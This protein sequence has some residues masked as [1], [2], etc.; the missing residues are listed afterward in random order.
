MNVLVVDDSRAIRNL[1]TA[2]VEEMGFRVLLAADGA[3]ALEVFGQHAVDLVLMDVEMPGINGFETTR[4][5]RARLK[6]EWLPI[7]YL[8]S[9][10]TDDYFVEG[11]QAGGDAYL[12][13]PVNGPVLQSM[14]RAMGRISAMRAALLKAN[15]DLERMAFVDILTDLTNRRGF[16]NLYAKEWARSNRDCSPLSV[17]LVDIDYFKGYNDNYGH[18]EG[19]DCLR[20]VARQ[21]AKGV[22]RPADTVARYGGEEFVVLLPDTDLSGAVEVA[23]RLRESVLAAEVRHEF[24]PAAPC[25]S[26]SIGVAQKRPEMSPDMLLSG[27]DACLYQAK[28]KGR[29]RVCAAL[30]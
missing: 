11:I 12:E 1:V 28:E 7:V 29:N 17:L 2:Y 14:V 5:M 3:E 16:M 9:K 26:V 4:R 30:D 10:S 21:L 24:S 23:E 19:D 8:S 27:A 20:R 25:V 15:E 13:K 6:D 22:L 18:L